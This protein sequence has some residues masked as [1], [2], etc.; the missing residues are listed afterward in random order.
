MS[1]EGEVGSNLLKPLTRHEI[2]EADGRPLL[3]ADRF[4]YQNNFRSMLPELFLTMSNQI[5][6]YYKNSPKVTGASQ[7]SLVSIQTTFSRYF[8]V[9]KI[10]NIET[11]EIT[12]RITPW[13]P[14]MEDW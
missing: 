6:M 14:I 8:L 3:P 5:P 2:I 13:M 9:E 10:K 11:Y 7:L 4:F 1:S 12:S